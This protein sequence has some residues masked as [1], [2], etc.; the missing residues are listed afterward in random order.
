MKL[1]NNTIAAVCA[2]LLFTALFYVAV[3]LA[4]PSP[5]KSDGLALYLPELAT[6]AQ[7]TGTVKPAAEPLLNYLTN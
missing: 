3:S 1:I 6:V 5:A 7:D 4:S 2:G